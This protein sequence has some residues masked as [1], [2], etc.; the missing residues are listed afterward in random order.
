MAVRSARRR[1][2][3]RAR[4]NAYNIRPQVEPLEQ[5]L[6]LSID[7]LGVPLWEPQ[8]PESL[9]SSTNVQVPGNRVS[10]AIQAIAVQPEKSNVVFVGTVNG[11]IWRSEN[12]NIL[13][14]SGEPHWVPL[15]DHY[16]SLAIGDLIISSRDNDNDGDGIREQVDE[17]TPW[18]NLVL[19]AGT[20][21]F[22]STRFE[23]NAAG[24]LKSTD[25]GQTWAVLGYHEL[26]GMR[27]SSV[28]ST[29]VPGLDDEVILVATVPETLSSGVITP[30]GQLIG[31]Y[32][33]TNGGQDFRQVTSPVDS[34]EDH[35]PVFREGITDLLIDPANPARIYAAVR[36]TGI[37]VSDNAGVS[38]NSASIG[39][40]GIQSASNIKLAAQHLGGTV[41][42]AGI[43]GANSVG[44]SLSGVFRSDDAGATW[45][46]LDDTQ[47]PA[48]VPLIH[49]GKQGDLHFSIAADPVAPN[50][51]YIGGDSYNGAGNLYSWDPG[52][53][54]NPI[55][56]TWRIMVFSGA[57]DTAPHADSRAM[58]F[59]HE[60]DLLQADDGG[61]Y[62]LFE[63]SNR[64]ARH[65][66]S[67]NGDLSINEQYSVAFDTVNDILFAGTQDNGT[68]Q[69]QT[70]N[71]QSWFEVL[72]GDGN[73]VAVD[74]SRSGESIHYVMANN[75]KTFYRD[76]Y[77][78]NTRISRTSVAL[79]GL[80]TSDRE[81]D[82]DKFFVTPYVLNAIDPNR[83]LIGQYRLYESR[84]QGQTVAM[85]VP[86]AGQL[87]FSALVYGGRE[88]VP[89]QPT[90]LPGPAFR[91]V[92]RPDV[93]YAARKNMIHV[94]EPGDA[95]FHMREIRGAGEIVD[96][97]LDPQNW[98][99]AYAVSRD[100][101]YRTDD[102][103]ATQPT[104]ITDSLGLVDHHYL[105]TIE[106]VE[107]TAGDALLVGMRDGV[108]QAI[109]PSTIE[110]MDQHEWYWT[111]LGRGLP[112]APVTD[113]RYYRDQTDSVLVAATMGRGTWVIR[114]A[115]AQLAIP[116]QLI[117]DG[118]D[119]NDHMLLRRDANNPLLLCA[120]YEHDFFAGLHDGTFA[121]CEQFQPP[122]PLASIETIIVRG[123]E[124]DDDLTI[125]SYTGPIGV[126]EILYDGSGDSVAGDSLTLRNYSSQPDEL[127]PNIP[128][129]A[130]V[131]RRFVLGDLETQRVI[132]QDVLTV[133]TYPFANFQRH[134]QN[135][136]KTLRAGLHQ[137]ASLGD[138][139]TFLGQSLPV[140]GTSL[141]RAVDGA[142]TVSPEPVSDPI[143][144]APQAQ[145]PIGGG[146]DTFFRRMFETGTGA[147]RIADI[148]REGGGIETPEALEEHLEA[149]DETPD[150]VQ[151]NPAGTPEGVELFDVRVV[152]K[153]LT[154]TAN[155]DV[156]VDVLGGTVRLVGLID[157]SADV[158]M[159]IRIGVDENGFFIDPENNID[160]EFSLR[161]IRFDGAVTASGNLGIVQVNMS[162]ARLQF[163]P[164]VTFS[165]N[166]NDPG[167]G[168]AGDGLIRLQNLYAVT[169]EDFIAAAL[170]GEL[171]DFA[172]E[173][174]TVDISGENTG[175]D[176]VLGGTFSVTPIIPGVEDE[177]NPFDELAG[178]SCADLAE[179]YETWGS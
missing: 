163:D 72:S 101:I 147:F 130:W 114:N 21:S 153:T 111:R 169:N 42:F 125:N 110:D 127:L 118:T 117:I 123:G 158:T 27:I 161:N 30:G 99:T 49:R 96:I 57:N 121:D 166:L 120:A 17:S 43:V 126:R 7:L 94:R 172:N 174:V 145:Q 170:F 102:A 137:S 74:D 105:S 83:L 26:A 77:R 37:F 50:V 79:R 71:A 44:S 173:L 67:R 155:L 65:W 98:R 62:K 176:V 40:N 128:S 51:V 23:G 151:H 167:R 150:N 14:A 32:R 16:P 84:N 2:Q 38:W 165:I 87:R 132:L 9:T 175:Q 90:D 41:L 142:N 4:R 34:S 39:L 54:S 133:H 152:D 68:V 3:K 24:V 116:A 13:P 33:S 177:D 135:P 92:D 108:Y 29:F 76:T 119:G 1:R 93:I 18:E 124:G 85:K 48:D 58:V 109:V 139:A 95:T 11:G 171:T 146:K 70:S 140:L 113:L 69:Q 8:G 12:A 46:Q 97:V 136:I 157:V 80:K 53:D 149:L 179:R 20:G 78:N 36:N 86:A 103:F 56:G 52:N 129:N 164:R 22:S 162:E 134:Q 82:P 73:T 60:N 131:T 47:R 6:V 115:S 107:G 66:I 178:A 156:D 106:Y 112:N 75:L 5:R 159:H 143:A 160:P 122:L 104:D 141:G 138:S 31:I 45:Q 35:F 59:D 19:Y 148:G 168:E 144:G 55:G 81:V 89:R 88:L 28:V 10:G 91:I 63:P 64:A 25:G 154:G 100:R 61:I 15:T